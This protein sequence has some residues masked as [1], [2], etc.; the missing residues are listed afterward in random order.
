MFVVGQPE[1]DRE[2]QKVEDE[3][4]VI[5]DGINFKITTRSPRVKTSHPIEMSHKL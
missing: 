5:L 3:K 4:F 2:A 1:C